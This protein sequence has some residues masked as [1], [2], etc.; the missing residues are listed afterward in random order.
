MRTAHTIKHNPVK[1]I[2]WGGALLLLC[3]GGLQQA[4]AVVTGLFPSYVDFAAAN[5]WV[6]VEID[7]VTQKTNLVWESGYQPTDDKDSDGLTNIQEF[8]GWKVKINGKEG[9]FTYNQNV[10]TDEAD[11]AFFGYG[12]DPELFD[13]D[14]DGISDLYESTKMITYAGTNPWAED[15]DGDG[16]KDPVEIYAGLDPKDNG[17]IYNT[18]VFTYTTDYAN[19]KGVIEGDKMQDPFLPDL[20]D[21]KTLQHPGM[22]I[23]GD[24]MTALQELKKANKDINF[25]EG[26]P[27][28]GETRD[29][30]PTEKLN[31]KPWTSPFDCDTD[32]DWLLDSFE[33]FFA[34]N[35]F[36]PV[37][38]E[39]VGDLFHYNS[40]PDKDG[41]TNFREQCLHPLLTYGWGN[42]LA[43]WPFM[44]SKCVLEQKEVTSAGLRFRQPSRGGCLHGTPGYLQQAKYSQWGDSVRY[45]TV[46]YTKADWTGSVKV[47]S[48]PG[49]PDLQ[50]LP[51]RIAWPSAASYWTEPRPNLVV[52]YDGW[53][54]DKDGLID[55]WE[56]EHGLNPKTGMAA[57]DLAEDEDEDDSGTLLGIV[58][59]PVEI[60]P[61]GALGDP[62]G[63]GLLNIQ[64]YF[65]QDG[66]RIDFITGTGDETIPWTAR[67]MNYPNQ[68]SFETY[69]LANWILLRHDWQAP[70]YY[71]IMAPG[72]AASYS[73]RDYP[74]FFHPAAYETTVTN[75]MQGLMV[76]TN[77]GPPEEVVTN[78]VFVPY[79]EPKLVP[80]VGV[81]SFP[82][83]AN[84]MASLAPFYGDGFTNSMG[85]GGF[86]PFTTS[87]SG[88]YYLEAAGAEDGRYTPGIDALWYA[89]NE[90]NVY[91][92]LALSTLLIPTNDVIL[93]DPDSILTDAET[94]GTDLVTGG[95]PVTDNL[96][97]MVPMPG[98]DTDA[99][100]L[101]DSTEIQMDVA[102]GKQ[103]TSPVQSLNPLVARS[104]K[105]L[106][107]EGSKTLLV[108]D[109]RYFSRDFTVEA[110]VYLEGDAPASGS[111]TKGYLMIG[112]N[113]RRAYDLGVTNVVIGGQ[114]VETVPYAGLHSLGGKW[115]QASATRPLPRNRWVHL[116]ATFDHRKNALSLYVDGTLVQSRQVVEETTGGY[117]VSTFGNG[118][119]LEFAKGSGFANRLWIDEL[120][121]WGIERSQA[122]VAANRSI[123]LEGRQMVTLDGQQLNG[124]LLAYY[125]FDDGGNVAVDSRHRAM[126]SLLGY[127]F[128][129]AEN[130]PNRLFHDHLYPDRAYALPSLALGGGFVFDAGRTAPVNGALDNQRGELDSDGDGLPD[131]WEIVHELNP[132]AWLTQ[133][134]TML[135]YDPGWAKMGVPEILIKRSGFTFNS[136]ADGGQTWASAT[137][138][139]IITVVNGVITTSVC[140]NTV[141]IGDYSV[142]TNT[143]VEGETTNTVLNT[144]TNWEIRSGQVSGFIDDGETW[145]VSKG[146]VAVAQVGVTGRMLSDAD[147]DPDGDGLTTLQ[148]YWARTN[149]RKPDTD[150]N[151]IPDG[152]EDFDGDGLSNRQEARNATRP[153]LA[154]TD[155]DG[156]SDNDEVFQGF[157]ASDSTS[158]KQYLTAYFTG[159][160]GSWL[161]VLDREAFVRNSWTLEAAVL[162]ARVDFLADGQGAP[163]FRRAVEEVTNGML[164]ANYELRVI[165]SGNNLYP[166]A[167]FVYKTASGR[168][169]V[170]IAVTGSVPLAVSATYDAA[171]VTHLAATYDGSG[172]RLTLFVNGQAVASRQDLN[173]SA[174]AMGEGPSSII[175]IGER[176]HGFVDELRLWSDVR[177]G[178]SISATMSQLLEGQEE[179]LAAYFNFDDGGWPTLSSNT[180]DSTRITNLLYSV[181]YTSPPLASDMVDGDTWVDGTTVYVNDS[182]VVGELT[183]VGPVFDG[184]G[185]VPGTGSANPGDFGWNHAERI[186]Y[187]YD[188]TDWL[189]WGKGRHW[190]ADARATIAGQVNTIAGITDPGNAWYPPT[191][192]DM[193]VCA[194]SNMV[195]IYNGEDATGAVQVLPADPLLPG[196]RFYMNSTES[197]VEWDGMAL[198]PVTS[199]ADAA[200]LYV[201]IQSEGVAF[202]YEDHVWRRWGFIPS[203]EDYAVLRDWENQWAHAAKMSGVVEFYQTAAPTG[204]GSGT[205]SDGTPSGG[206]DTDGDGLP[207]AWEI[208]YGL[209]EN[210]G[211]FGDAATSTVDVDGDGRMD[212][213]F[214]Q[215]DFVNG[216]WGDPDDDGLN[217]RAEFLAGT[218][219]FEFDTDGDGTGDYDSPATGAS[220]GSLYMDGDNMP[221]GWESLFPNA[222]SPLRFDANLDPDGDGWDNYSE[223]MA[224]YKT[225]SANVYEVTTN[226]EGEVSSNLISS[227]GFSVPYCDPD[228]PV[229]YPKPSITFQFKTDCPEVDGTLRIWAYTD[230]AMNCPDAMT[231]LELEEPIR[232]G[233]SLNITDWTNGGHLRQG[234]NYFMAFVDANNDGQWNT[235][236][237]MGFSEYMPENIQWGEAKIEIALR[238]KANGFARF[239]W[240]TTGGDTNA[241]TGGS[242]YTVT[243]LRNG[244]VVYETTRG[245]CAASRNYLHEYDF[246]N[247]KSGPWADISAGPMSGT[248]VCKVFDQN[249]NEIAVVTNSVN[250][251]TNLVNPTIISPVGSV[252]FAQ[253]HLQ[254]T[255]DPNTAQ[256][257]I[258]VQNASGTETLLDTTVFAPYIDRN[259]RAE[260]DLPFLAGWNHF[261]NGAYRIQVTAINP[262][263]S[264]SSVWTSF[265]VNLQSPAASGAGMITGRAYYYGF[266]PSPNIVV[267]AYEGS[268]FDQRPV[269]RV[270]ADANYNYRLMGLRFGQ[271]ANYYVR[272][273]QDQDN[274]GVLDPGEAWGLV[275]GQPA[276]VQRFVWVEAAIRSVPGRKSKSGA[277]SKGGV[278]IVP[279]TSIYAVD[280]S[281]KKIEIK[282]ATTVS[283]N[284]LVIHDADTDNDGLADIWEK[285]YSGGLAMNQFTD[286]DGDGLTDGDEF[287]Y[288][289][290]P[291]AMGIPA[292]VDPKDSDSDGLWDGAEVNTHG[293]NP[294][295]ADTDGDGLDDEEEVTLGADGYI[296]NP[297]AA[298]SDNDGLTDSQEMAA[299][300]NP[301]NPDTDGDSLP[302][303]WEVKYGL[304]PLSGA[305]ADGATGDPDTDGLTNAQE[306]ARGTDP[307]N[308]DTDGD[309]LPD[310]W[311]V[312]MGLNPLSAAGDN[313]ANGDPDNDGLSNAQ[314]LDLGSKPLVSDTDGDGLNDGAEVNTHGTDPLN[315][316][317]DHDTLPDGWEVTYGLNP[318]S[319]AG[320][321]G[322]TGDPDGDGLPN[323]VELAQGTNPVV[324]D[325]DGDGLDDGQEVLLGT[326]PLKKDTDSDG[327]EDGWE[328][329]HGLDPLDD[330]G[331]NGATGD[332]DGDWLSNAQE[333]FLGTHPMRADSDYDGLDDG[334]ELALHQTDPRLWDTDGDGFNDGVEV[335]QGTD[336][337]DETDLPSSG[338]P[339]DGQIILA[340]PVDGQIEVTFTVT[341]LPTPPAILDVLENNDL[342]D[343]AGWVPSGVQQVIT[344]TGTY[345]ILVPDLDGDGRLFIKIECK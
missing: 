324:A 37:E 335:D 267:E 175:R 178:A 215:T 315:P 328:V 332:P 254:M 17:F 262:R 97:L 76:V 110:W 116:A 16:L 88:L 115:Y 120:R 327:L 94:A 43:I 275:K 183:G 197:I 40:D 319:D 288:G 213:I 238:E 59:L 249:N 220:Y 18:D 22:D 255:L 179:G 230:P 100:G 104:A 136:S 142:E 329:D 28:L 314:E 15:T 2:L 137:C 169:G 71:E 66:Y 289:T 224:Y 133:E 196:H 308:D 203:T 161:E 266:S 82:Y 282:S 74:G 4:Q 10:V 111:F 93:S 123:L 312:T 124:A 185:I 98:T 188:G 105:I 118:G 279:A 297:L 207:D 280:Y 345:T 265:T 246:R 344:A 143:T 256:I 278:S 42:P 8:N 117:L 298:D 119:Q 69:V 77:P 252:L 322:A 61:S 109:P 229:S 51:G 333:L 296:T 172:K 46:D 283:G 331:D 192:G 68:S 138:P 50:S 219:P 194:P 27:P 114:T 108:D 237:L 180:W 341:N 168:I 7:Q 184:T 58:D 3:S 162:P 38:A 26:C 34:K 151:G 23:D 311:E 101:P 300:T 171:L 140:P 286:T 67:A 231:S 263:V 223:Y 182:G 84:D 95:K 145:W 242:G 233:N 87:F 294:L 96:P 173:I 214:N 202:K 287:K 107:D 25:A 5:D 55:G 73:M 316:D 277:A 45:F 343:G 166:Q 112:G 62:D 176:F 261:T 103:P 284:D 147:S 306:L 272:A 39:P 264:K 232:D 195:Y 291:S 91:T 106:T 86:Q 165:R 152:D 54:T 258:Q 212:Y 247:N 70:M 144:V 149:P 271:E 125:N 121:I 122:E 339:A 305:G 209:N 285:Y 139:G 167:R 13:T 317:T 187:R 32:N 6:K 334:E 270:K 130:V 181:R 148:E 313:G 236:E 79:P 52:R 126:S 225:H 31:D 129:G 217:N 163:I 336:P 20:G 293:T 75:W 273:F 99:D 30:F 276:S 49:S 241:T 206:K 57:F 1:T 310:G 301:N 158:P 83:Y 245:G 64:E 191:L 177:D 160:P 307:R 325:T 323:D 157:V 268:G 221:D 63:D 309:G 234:R 12:P 90:A 201:T 210:D 60:N 208:R 65:G 295:K 257:R 281:N 260:M 53:D 19:R 193:F 156:M 211:G 218:N 29:H 320:N 146:G 239:D 227:T 134:H 186:L 48:S 24:G 174:P 269:A 205:G 141:L 155:D 235:G 299:T 330:T 198:V 135:E 159:R 274:D 127:D 153:D 204:G 216:A 35:G 11:P 132:F 128:P 304:N 321:D 318:L 33:K 240:A 200:A 228:D 14:C 290:Y 41:L 326:D 342:T 89:R 170:P 21:V 222:C 337:R 338:G 47:A 251:P 36:K 150:E 72:L 44:S 154:D 164:I 131:S 303:G 302:D 190:L 92:P 259:G 81:P 244:Q 102:R 9:W 292:G 85:T 80:T 56:V 78:V 340:T 253:E 199:A 189:R 243:V 113:E 250:Y 248:Y 226:T